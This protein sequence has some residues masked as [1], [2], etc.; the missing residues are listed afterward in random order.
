MKASSMGL[1]IEINLVQQELERLRF[2]DLSTYL[3][4]NIEYVGRPIQRKIPFKLHY[5]RTNKDVIQVNQYPV[6]VYFGEAEQILITLFEP[7]YR[8]LTELGSCVDR[9]YGATGK[10]LILVQSSLGN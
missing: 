6:K 2:S 7:H 5:S 9:F 3:N 8:E 10:V 4:F 1:E